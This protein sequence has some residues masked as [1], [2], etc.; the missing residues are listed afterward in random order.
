MTGRDLVLL[1][2]VY[3]AIGLLVFWFCKPVQGMVP[4]GSNLVV[5]FV[6]VNTKV[7]RVTDGG[8]VCY[9]A[10]GKLHGYTVSIDCVKR[11]TERLHGDE[12]DN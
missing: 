9:V 6:D 10:V 12:K 11:Y 7:Y 2:I 5:E 3:I 8:V 4:T 1:I